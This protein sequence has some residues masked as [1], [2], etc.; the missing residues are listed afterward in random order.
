MPSTPTGIAYEAVPGPGGTVPLLFLHAGIADRRMWDAQWGTLAADYGALRVDLRGFGESDV[1]PPGSFS[2]V[3]DVLGVLTHS[4]VDRVHLVGSSFG[5]GVA[6]EL[7]LTLPHVV[8]SL[9][10]APV[11]GSLLAEATDD[12]RR[13]VAA[14]DAALAAGDREAGVRLNVDTWLVGSGRHRGDLPWGVVQAVSEMQRRAFEVDEALGEL[15]EVELDPPA[16]ERLEELSLPVT[17]LLGGHDLEATKLATRHLQASVP[18]AEVVEWEGV[19]HLP[20]MERPA[21]FD[22][23]VRD[24]VARV[25]A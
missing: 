20:S 9:A 17:V 16:T 4:G 3:A 23:L 13:F 22:A 14:E 1:A 6:V 25:G 10:L 15:D 5:A 12:L 7:A 11:G 21:A 2:H 19:A 18:H 24:H 8:A